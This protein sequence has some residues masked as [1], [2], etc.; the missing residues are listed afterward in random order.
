MEKYDRNTVVARVECSGLDCLIALT[1]VMADL[2]CLFR[3]GIVGYTLF[4]DRVYK[5]ERDRRS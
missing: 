4:Y 2:Y 5:R 1:L 3:Q